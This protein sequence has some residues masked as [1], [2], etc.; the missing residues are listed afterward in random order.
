MPDWKEEITRRL[1]SLKLAPAR[2]AEIAEEVAQHLEDR[3]QELV[4]SGSTETEARRLAFEELSDENLLARGLRQVEAEAEPEPMVPGGGGGSNLLASFVQDLRVGLRMLA[5]NPGFTIVAVLTLA[6]GIGSN[7]A[8]FSLVDQALLRSLPVQ[9]PEQLVVVNSTDQKSGHTSTDYSLDASFSYPMYKDLREKNRVFSGLLAVFPYVDVNVAWQGKPERAFADLVSGN[10]FQVLG[11]RA[12]LGRVFSPQDE[13]APGANPVVVLSYSYWTQHFGGNPAVLN[14]TVDINATPLTVVGVTQPGFTGV[15]L[16]R[17]SELYIPITMMPQMTPTWNGLDSV[18]DYFLGI[19]GRLDPGMSRTRAQAGLQPVFHAILES[20]LPIM[21]AKKTVT[22]RDAEKA[23]L[24]GKIELTPGARGRPVLQTL[25]QAPL[26]L[27]MAMVGL[28]LLI[29][30][31]N[32]AGLLLAR[33]EARQHEIAVRM[34][35]GASRTRLI[36]QLLTESLIVAMAGG[37]VSLLVGWWT[38]RSIVTAI[39]VVPNWGPWLSSGLTGNLDPRVLAFAGAVTLLS[40]LFFGLLPALRASR[41]DLQISLKEQGSSTSGGP[42]SVR[43]RGLLVVAQV[44]STV[45]LL[46]AAALFG[47]GLIRLERANLGMRI[48]HLVQ[49]SI[50]PGLSQYSPARAVALLDRLRQD[51]AALPGVASVSAAEYPLL[52]LSF[53]TDTMKFEDH[54][55]EDTTVSVNYVGPHFFSTMGIPLILGREFGEGDSSSNRKIAVI[56]EKVAQQFFPRRNPIGMHLAIGWGPDVHPDVEIVGVVANTKSLHP[57]DPGQPF[58]YFPYAQD[59]AVSGGTFYVSAR[60]DPGALATELHR[61]AGQDA[62]NLPVFDIRT[63]EEQFDNS[64]SA[65]R[66]LT[67]LILSLALLAALLAAVG[68]YGVMAYV[69]TRRRR[70]IALRMALGAQKTDVL[71]DVVGKGLKLALIGLAVGIGGALALTRLVSS[72]LYGVNPTDPLAFAGV[73]LA[74]IAVALAACYIPARRV[75]KV[76][77]MVALRYE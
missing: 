30:C 32:L 8:I 20:E 21:T 75:T 46:I 72:L 17:A 58:V 22:S 40:T 10:F 14:Q 39:A 12:V 4:A 34:A 67:F 74:L 29:A 43:L 76:D 27:V 64:M 36:R 44:A 7:V 5:R 6:L 9:H 2:E 16:G 61:V 49:F 65:D 15:Q 73:S 25:A 23:V 68:L 50:D 37:A 45:V 18:T 59:P 70:E 57:R 35:M 69:V 56:N 33:G 54:Q 71:K 62:P 3:Y 13:T 24:A 77:P 31:A 47:E 53:N 19:V 51:I 11:V 55:G 63:V 26:A 42:G 48:D 41:G 52:A 28:V 66:L 60:T 1:Q 38:L